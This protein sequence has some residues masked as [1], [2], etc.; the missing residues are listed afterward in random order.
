MASRGLNLRAEIASGLFDGGGHL[1]FDQVLDVSEGLLHLLLFL[2]E[3]RRFVSSSLKLSA[4][5]LLS[6]AIQEVFL[7][8]CTKLFVNAV[9]GSAET[10]AELFRSVVEGTVS[11]RCDEVGVGKDGQDYREHECHE[12]YGQGL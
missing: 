1:F 6:Q 10:L 5:F 11:L 4:V 8:Q 3:S 2:H 7:L 12:E 9:P